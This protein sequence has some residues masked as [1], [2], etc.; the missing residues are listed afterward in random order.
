MGRIRIGLS[1]W[2]DKSWRGSFYPPPLA[3]T[4]E[5]TYAAR[6]M[7]T[8]EVNGTFYGLMSPDSFRRWY[9]SVPAGFVF[10][11][12][13][14]RFITHNKKLTDVDTALAQFYE[15]AIAEAI[16]KTNVTEI[17]LRNWFESQLI[18]EAGTRGTVYRGAADTGDL[19]NRTVDLLVSR[20]LLR[21][22]VR[23][24]GT[25]YELIHDRLVDPILQ[26]NQGWSLK[27]PLIQMAQDWIDSG[28]PVNKLLEGQQL[29]E[30]LPRLNLNDLRPN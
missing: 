29:H 25:W 8:L 16:D 24:G 1:G 27:Q 13:G 17:E 20:F 14:S 9:D 5:L 12:K 21:A 18:T 11:V 30:A 10:A 4:D 28:H 15:Q 3:R 26:S 6:R 7:D 22:E 23:S 2:E 19:P